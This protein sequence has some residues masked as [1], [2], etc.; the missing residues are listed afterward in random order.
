[1][2]GVVLWAHIALIT[3]EVP[4]PTNSPAIPFAR[5]AQEADQA[6]VA[7]RV[8]DAIQLYSEA[9]RMRPSWSEGWWSLET[10]YYDEDRFEEARA[11]LARFV[12]LSRPIQRLH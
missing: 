3:A 9:V 4:R 7:N 6:R 1:M 2:I 11:A 12:P 5:I 8:A 10:L